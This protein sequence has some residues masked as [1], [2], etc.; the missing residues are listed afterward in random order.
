MILSEDGP[1]LRR[2]G[3]GDRSSPDVVTAVVFLIG[4]IIPK[5]TF[6]CETIKLYVFVEKT[7]VYHILYFTNIKRTYIALHIVN[8]HGCKTNSLSEGVALGAWCSSSGGA[9]VRQPGWLI[10]RSTMF[11]GYYNYG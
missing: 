9:P 4:S 11:Y 5:Y 8:A 7:K 6:E 1:N 10:T 2:A 3:Q